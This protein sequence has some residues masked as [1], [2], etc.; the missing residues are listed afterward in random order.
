MIFWALQVSSTPKAR[1]VGPCRI[2][3]KSGHW[4]RECLNEGPQSN[5]FNQ[6][7]VIGLHLIRVEMVL[8]VVLVVVQVFKLRPT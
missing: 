1:V 6:V 8:G 5:S 4:S 2:C 3:R 7:S